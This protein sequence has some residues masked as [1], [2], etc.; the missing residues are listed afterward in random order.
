MMITW[1]TISQWLMDITIRSMVF[2][3]G[4][5]V[6]PVWHLLE[7]AFKPYINLALLQSGNA[8]AL[9][10][11]LRFTVALQSN[12]AMA[13][14]LLPSILLCLL[15]QLLYLGAFG[16]LGTY[17]VKRSRHFLTKTPSPSSSNV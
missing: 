15:V 12:P 3:V 16:L 5:F 17:L 8:A 9:Q 13:K 6:S 11:M 14:A 7:W 4:S 10:E 2:L 1:S